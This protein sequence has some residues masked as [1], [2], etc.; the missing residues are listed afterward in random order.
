MIKEELSANISPNML[1]KDELDDLFPAFGRALK[2]FHL[3]KYV[4][5]RVLHCKLFIGPSGLNSYVYN[6]MAMFPYK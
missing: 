3:L 2:E 1:V 4:F 5:G 6:G